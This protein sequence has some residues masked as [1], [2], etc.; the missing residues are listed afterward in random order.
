MLKIEPKVLDIR[1]KERK[2][3]RMMADFG[4]GSPK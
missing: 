3:I 4:T 2:K 1:W